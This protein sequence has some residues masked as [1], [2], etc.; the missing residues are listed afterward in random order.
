LYVVLGES[1]E[2]VGEGSGE[3]AGE[4]V[5]ED[6]GETVGT[7]LP[8]LPSPPLPPPEQPGNTV[9]KRRDII[10]AAKSRTNM[11]LIFVRFILSLQFFTYYIISSYKFNT[12]NHFFC[13]NNSANSLHSPPCPCMIVLVRLVQ[14]INESVYYSRIRL[15]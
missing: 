6:V 8:P 5:G 1:H 3:G 4:E 2:V 12:K 15:E 11:V 9:M 10:R 13:Y 7:T 14:S